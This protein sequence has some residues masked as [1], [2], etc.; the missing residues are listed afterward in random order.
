MIGTTDVVY[1]GDPDNFAVTERD[2]EEFVR[3]INAAYPG[4]CLKRESVTFWYGGLRPITEKNVERAVS[5]AARKY[6]ITD[7]AKRDRIQ[8]L[9]SVV[10][11]KYTT[12]RLLAEKVVDFVFR[13]LGYDAPPR[14]LTTRKRLFGGK[15][16][17]FEDFLRRALREHSRRFGEKVVRRL[18]YNYGSE[19][20]RIL[21]YVER[22]AR[23]GETLPGSPEVLKAE[24]VHGIREEAACCLTDVVMRRT[25]LGC[26]GN[27][28]DEALRACAEIAA[29]EL[30]WERA[31]R[32]KELNDVKKVFVPGGGK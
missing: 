16:E 1:R 15:I 32:E 23:L 6:E 25:D 13:K 10:G 18:V 22:D 12:C 4:A 29:A 11:V 3:E 24:I 2:I 19:Y 31:R 8:G 9:I 26:L 20:L 5:K 27:P 7:H 21:R 14:T 28:G 30:G 17:R